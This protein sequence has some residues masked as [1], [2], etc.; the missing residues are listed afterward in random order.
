M[1]EFVTHDLAGITVIE[2]SGRL[3][4]LASPHLDAVLKRATEAG[5]TRLVVD[6]GD[7]S[8]ISSSCLRMLLIGVRRAR[9][10]GGDLKLCCLSPR[11]H[12]VFA[13][14]G[15]DQVFDLCESRDEALAVFDSSPGGPERLCG[16][17]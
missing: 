9:D 3:D 5:Q 6:F 13:L 15:F 10:Q 8:Y 1:I 11:V 2:A 7:V 16:S 14:A 12:Q 4:A 17:A